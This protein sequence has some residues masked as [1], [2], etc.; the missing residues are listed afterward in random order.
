MNKAQLIIEKSLTYVENHL[1]EKI[2]L[3]DIALNVGVSKYHLHRL[4]KSLTGE[5]IISYATSRKLTSS[6]RELLATD[7]RIIDIAHEYGF[8]YEQSYIRAFQKEYGC[9]PLKIRNS[10]EAVPIKEK[11]M[12]N[13]IL[14]VEEA[15]TYR[16]FFVMKP[17]F[18]LVGIR[19]EIPLGSDY[20]IPNKVGREFFYQHRPLIQNIVNPDVYFGYVNWRQEKNSGYTIYV[21]SVQVEKVHDIPNGMTVISIP[22]NKYVVFR[23]V[24]FFHPEQ[25]NIKHFEHLLEYMYSKWITQAGYD[26]AE[27]FHLE[28][29]DNN[30][31][32]DDYCE[33]D[34][35][36]PI[37][38]RVN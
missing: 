12:I 6:I 20:L 26:I 32:K 31:A 38:E 1:K 30:I 22:D 23:F 37:K 4:F 28:R 35:Y 14:S 10:G 2:V 13:E 24:G 5:T 3:E 21:P 15:I 18:Q 17:A 36:Q 25:V 19:H 8:E 11:I 7:L 33:V 27:C 34:L 16:P 9:T 29:I